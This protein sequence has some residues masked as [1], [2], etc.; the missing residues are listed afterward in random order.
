MKLLLSLIIIIFILGLV[1]RSKGD[2]LLDTMSSGFSSLLS[3]F[4]GCFTIILI[5]IVLL[6]LLYF[7][8]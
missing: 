8:G 3:M 6:M 5:L 4:G 2:N 1:S 7:L